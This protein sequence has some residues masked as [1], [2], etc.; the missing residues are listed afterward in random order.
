MTNIVDPDELVTS[1]TAFEQMLS[2][3]NVDKQM[4]ELGKTIP[5]TRSVAKKDSLIKKI[6]FLSGLKKSETRPQD[7][8]I[9]H[10]MPVAPPVVR[11]V[12]PMGGNR[13]EYADV[14]SLYR[15]HML[16]NEPFKK[17]KDILPNDQLTN[18][19]KDMY[20]GAKAIFGLGEA[21]TGSSR[22]KH[23]K[24]FLHQIS[25]DS[26]PKGGLFHSKLLSKKQDFSGRAT[27]YAEPN[28]GFNEVA[29]P[30]EM[31]WSL[32]KFHIIRDLVK[33]GFDYVSAVKAVEARSPA[34][35]NVFNK[36]IKQIPMILNR[37]P[38]LM[39]TNITAHYPVPIDGKTLGINPMHLPM[40]AGDFDGDALSVF[41]PMTPQA[42]EEAKKKLLPEQHIHDLRKGLNN[43]MVAP[44]HEAIIGSVYMT[45][46]DM[47]QKTVVFKTEAEA[48]AAFKKGDIKE[49]TPIEIRV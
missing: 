9:I 42:I 48:I 35:V 32:Y 44:A 25:G 34:A 14:N 10:N 37:A 2:A 1:G 21:I 43:S 46:P 3:V 40:Y 27:I 24:G 12:I 29:A 4:A 8:F 16:V 38:T 31:I 7:A 45:E 23:L 6:K 36:V 15:D 39:R 19:R 13:I 11:P 17:I 28:L 33:Q 18:E 20:N 47:S 49:N 41:V 26:G 22:G 30:K 5:V